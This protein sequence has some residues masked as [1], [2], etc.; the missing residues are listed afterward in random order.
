MAYHDHFCAVPHCLQR[1]FLPPCHT[2]CK[3]H[4]SMHCFNLISQNSAEFYRETNLVHV[5]SNS[6]FFH[7]IIVTSTALVEEIQQLELQPVL[8]TA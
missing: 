4:N 1:S 5:S 2:L 7:G 6:C 8:F 3:I